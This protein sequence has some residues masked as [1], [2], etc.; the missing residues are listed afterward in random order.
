MQILITGGAGF[1]G[2]Y[3]AKHFLKRFPDGKIILVDNFTRSK[4]YG[5]SIKLQKDNIKSLKNKYRERVEFIELDIRDY[6]RLYKVS[7][8]IDIVIHTAAQV[9]VLTS[10]RDPRLDHE[11]N[12]IGTLN[13]LEVTRRNDATFVYC[14]TNKVYG[15]NVNKIP[16]EEYETRYDYVDPKYRGIGIPEN[17]PIDLSAHTPYGISKLAGDLYTQ[18]YY[19][20]YGLKTG[21]FRMSCIYGRRQ[22][23][24]EEQGWISWFIKAAMKGKTLTIYGTG[25]QV[26]D[27]LHVKDLM[28]AW[29]LFIKK[30]EVKHAVYNIGGGPQN[31]ISI[32]ELVKFIERE[33]NKRI[34][35]RYSSWR[36]HDQKVYYSNINKLREELG[37]EPQINKY[38]GIRNLI[39]KHAL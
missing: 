38:D 35:V 10:I 34:C 30:E 1:I 20:T 8:G 16:I 26:R 17:F 5:V 31:T 29:E 2:Y 36:P 14:S 33:L 6:E 7:K 32:I 12:V 28:R 9:G 25:K 13:L 18:E 19:Y 11:I 21:V 3:A 37:W 23:G 24:V 39:K 4:L 22:L 15:D 27:I